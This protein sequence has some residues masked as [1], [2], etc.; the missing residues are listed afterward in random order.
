MYLLWNARNGGWLTRGGTYS[1]EL[2]EARPFTRADAIEM[3][4]VH[5]AMDAYGLIPVDAEMMD[6]VNDQRKL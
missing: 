1:S 2:P 4:K 6:D 5:K 3:C